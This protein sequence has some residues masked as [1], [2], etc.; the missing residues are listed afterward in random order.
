M[1]ANFGIPGVI[2]GMA[3]IGSLLALLVS[4]F[5]NPTMSPLE[6]VTGTAVIY[7]L[8]YPHSNLSL[9]TG[10]LIQFAI[11]LWIYFRVGLSIGKPT[12]RA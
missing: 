6:F 8:A 4:V 3:I 1:Y 2:L 9:M 7:W 12:P 5:N 11:C 10:S